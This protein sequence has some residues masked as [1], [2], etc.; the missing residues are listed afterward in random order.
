MAEMEAEK[1]A[2]LA[3]VE[4]HMLTP[5]LGTWADVDWCLVPGPG[6]RPGPRFRDHDL[7]FN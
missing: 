7:S 2:A 4:D 1:D 6:V 3:D 5:L